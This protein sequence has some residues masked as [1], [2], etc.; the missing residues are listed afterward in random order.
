MMHIGCFIYTLLVLRKM[1]EEKKFKKK[2]RKY[3]KEITGNVT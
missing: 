2:E 3:E 1:T